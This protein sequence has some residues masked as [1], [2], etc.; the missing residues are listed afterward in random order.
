M[1]QPNTTTPNTLQNTAGPQHDTIQRYNTTQLRQHTQ[2][3]AT[4]LQHTYKD[5][6][7]TYTTTTTQH[8]AQG[9]PEHTG[10]E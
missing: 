3:Q 7:N 5:K 10:A 9:G 1:Q 8:K 6:Y 4:Q 2:L